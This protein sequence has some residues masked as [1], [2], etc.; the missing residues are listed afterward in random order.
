MVPHLTMCF[1]LLVPDEVKQEE[2]PAQPKAAEVGNE[3]P[4][5]HSIELI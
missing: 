5:D 1:P 2:T 4:V 3:H